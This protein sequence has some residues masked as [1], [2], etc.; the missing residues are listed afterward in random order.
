MSQE[1]NRT[2][3]TIYQSL[4]EIVDFKLHTGKT[5]KCAKKGTALV[6]LGKI[7]VYAM[8]KVGKH[9]AEELRRLQRMKQT[10]RKVYDADPNN[11]EE[12]R[13]QKI[14]RHNYQRSQEM[15]ESVRKVGMS[16]SPEDASQIITHLLNVGETATLSARRNLVCEIKAPNGSLRVL[17]TWAILPNGNK[18]LSTLNFIPRGYD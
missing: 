14:L 3:G 10:K 9:N 18:Y 8:G 2:K 5:V 4:F 13:K 16:D 12:L 7:E 11:E 17:S 6:A 15:F 1:E